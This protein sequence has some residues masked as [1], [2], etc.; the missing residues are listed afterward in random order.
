MKRLYISFLSVLIMMLALSSCREEPAETAQQVSPVVVDKATIELNDQEFGLYY[1][2]KYRNQSGVFYVVLSDAACYRDGYSEPY[3]DSQGDMLVLEL[4]TSVIREGEAME[5]PSGKYSLGETRSG[6]S[7]IIADA[8]YVVRLEGHT[9]SRYEI[10]SGSINVV[11]TPEGGYDIV[12]EDF[13]LKKNGVEYPVSYSFRGDLLLEDYDVVAPRLITIEDDVIDMPFTDLIGLYYGNLYG[14]GTANYVMTLYTQGFDETTSDS[15][16]LLLTINCFADLISGDEVPELDPGRY[17]V[18]G[19]FDATEFSIL[20]G[21][22]TSSAT[23]GTYAFGSYVYQVDARGGMIIDYISSGTMDVSLDEEGVY[24][25]AYDFKTQASRTIKGTW[26]GKIPFSNLA[27]DDDRVVL[28][29]LED[30]VD[31]DMSKIETGSLAYVETLKTTAMEPEDISE[32]WRLSLQPRDFTEEEKKLPWD[33]RIE[34]YCPDGDAMIFE[35]VLPLGSDG[36]PAPERG[37]EYVYTIQ[38]DLALADYDYQLCVSKMGRPYDDIFDPAQHN[39]YYFI[40]GYDFCNSRR[41]F[42]WS[43]DGYRGVWYFHYLEKHWLNMDEHAPAIRGEIKIM[44]TSAP[45]VVNGKKVV[46]MNIEWNLIDD[47]DAANR[48]RGSWDGPVTIHK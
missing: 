5:I 46:N 32:V 16:G 34:I 31:C 22:T 43:S 26:I 4:N 38:P 3:L 18:T 19:V 9:Q 13:V 1:G 7:S 27:T 17:T 35:F 14:Y 11:R 29:T 23:G 36:N 25:I 2:D 10:K 15:P 20:Y 24:T 44:S 48:I 8:S 28:S 33:E 45:K 42:T 6:Q 41:G 40:D 47:S 30:D 12:T 21:L 39:M 37:R